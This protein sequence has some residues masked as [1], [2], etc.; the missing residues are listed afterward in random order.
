MDYTVPFNRHTKARAQLDYVASSFRN[1]QTSGDGP[2]SEDCRQL[3]EAE[4][5]VGR[6]ML[7]PSCTAALELAALTLDLSSNDEVIVPSFTFVSSASA[8]ALRGSRVVFADI[9]PDTLTLDP[10]Q[11]RVFSTAST[12]AIVPVHYAGVACEMDELYRIANDVGA[13][14]VEDNAHG[15]FGRYRDSPLGTMGQLATVSF[16]D[17]KN[18]TCGEGGALFVNDL[19]LADR[20]E[21]LREKGTNRSRFFRGEVD[22]YTWVDIG[23]SFLLSDILAA[24]LLAQLEERDRIQQRRQEIWEAYR[25]GLSD[26][27][28]DNDIRLPVVPE[29]SS[30]A[31]HMFYMLMHGPGERAAF[32]AHLRDAGVQAVFHY[33]PLHLSEVGRSLGGREGQFPVTERVSESL[34][35]LPFFTDMTL[36][37]QEKVIEAVLSFRA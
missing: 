20:A 34:V 33:L 21:I 4:L 15:L 17:T 32:I 35:R 11:V 9:R 6:V 12:R 10:E 5:G 24:V 30:Q 26:W 3:L 22:K 29:H 1:Q 14:I 8:F 31:F 23:S 7:T 28:R 36:G 2:F 18:F 25:S 19:E 27:A 16:H 37:E 13:A